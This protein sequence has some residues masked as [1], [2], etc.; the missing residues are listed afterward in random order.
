[1]TGSGDANLHQ[2]SLNFSIRTSAFREPSSTNGVDFVHEDDTWLVFSG[3]TE[4]FSDQPSRLADILVDDCRRDN[5]EE[6]CRQS[7][8][9]SPRKEGLSRPW[10]P[11]KQHTFRWL[12][13][14]AL[15]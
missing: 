9:D 10:R 1:M 2:C 5:F 13:T 6:V 11:V 14:D 3:V 15:E 12:Y 8:G 7:C 4:H